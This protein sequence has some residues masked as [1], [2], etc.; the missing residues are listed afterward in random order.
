MPTFPFFGGTGPSLLH[1]L[2]PVAA[3]GRL[4]AVASLVVELGLWG[5]QVQWMSRT[6]LAA[7]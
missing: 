1:G 4:T 7:P 6:G 2:S 5:P 3:L